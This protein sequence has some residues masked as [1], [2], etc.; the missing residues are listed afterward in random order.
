MRRGSANSGGSQFYIVHQDATHLDGSY[1]VFGSVVDGM[2][3]VDAITEL[4]LDVY[5]RY[6][7][8]NRPYPVSAVI[9]SVTI[10][11]ATR[12]TAASAAKPAP[13]G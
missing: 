5:G 9:D 12:G 3:V 4:E 7:P 10:E 8:R 13:R 6:G 11:P 2:E 1:S